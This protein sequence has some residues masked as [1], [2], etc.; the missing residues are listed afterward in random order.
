MTEMNNTLTQ[1]TT[2]SLTIPKTSGSETVDMLYRTVRDFWYE[3]ISVAKVR[4]KC[5]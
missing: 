4:E 2:G 5:K 1:M 3:K